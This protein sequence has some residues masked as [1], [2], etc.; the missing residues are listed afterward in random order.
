MLPIS[1][2]P[3]K[4]ESLNIPKELVVI[5]S[6][7]NSTMIP[8]SSTYHYTKKTVLF[9]QIHLLH[10]HCAKKWE[11]STVNLPLLWSNSTTCGLTW[12]FQWAKHLENLEMHILPITLSICS[13]S[14]T[15]LSLLG[16]R[17]LN[18]L[19]RNSS[20]WGLFNSSIYHPISSKQWNH[21]TFKPASCCKLLWIHQLLA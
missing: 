18:D 13:L 3:S 17:L 20:S 21:M 14:M 16:Q 19:G 1:N 5:C 11:K 10:L 12:H 2:I 7:I 9:E 6:K 4:S 8:I 15:L